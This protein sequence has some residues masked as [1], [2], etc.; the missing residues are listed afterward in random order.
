MKTI[1][2]KIF[3]TAIFTFVFLITT[4]PQPTSKFA[5]ALAMC[6][7]RLEPVALSFFQVQIAG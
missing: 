2:S 5:V 4:N 7:L 6:L 3:L 1:F